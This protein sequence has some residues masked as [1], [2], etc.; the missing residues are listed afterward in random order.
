[1]ISYRNKIPN[2]ANNGGKIIVDVSME[3]FD[4]IYNKKFLAR[5]ITIV[6]NRVI[7]EE[8]AIIDKPYE[9]MDLFTDYETE[10]RAL[11]AER[12]ARDREKHMQ[13]ALLDIKQKFGKNTIIKD[14]NLQEA[15]PLANVIR[16]LAVMQN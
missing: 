8:K 11:E 4:K 15:R 12:A 7:D 14:M 3:L 9:Q 16:R 5:R 13:K 1:M 6:A 10:Q 2:P